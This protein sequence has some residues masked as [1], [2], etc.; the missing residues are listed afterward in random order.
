MSF[1]LIFVLEDMIM[2]V[3]SMDFLD[4]YYGLCRIQMFQQHLIGL[5]IH[6]QERD[7]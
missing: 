1:R 3:R 5:S 4:R 7:H 6:K 2:C